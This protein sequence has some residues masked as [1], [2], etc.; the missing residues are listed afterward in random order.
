APNN[1]TLSDTS[2]TLDFIVDTLAPYST[3]L[4]MFLDACRVEFPYD[5]KRKKFD[6]PVTQ[7]KHSLFYGF[8]ANFNAA[9]FGRYKPEDQ[10]S[11]FSDA[12]EK[13][14]KDENI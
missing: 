11:P 2:V 8:A 3:I 5:V 6:T 14:I 7:A 1:E 4:V 12:L 13:Q 10:N 9:A